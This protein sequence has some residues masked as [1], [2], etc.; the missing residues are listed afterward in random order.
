MVTISFDYSDLDTL[1]CAL[2]SYKSSCKEMLDIDGLS[3]DFYKSQ[4]NEIRR[5][6]SLLVKI[7][8]HE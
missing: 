4:F 3:S 5:I 6:E 2:I 8:N 7:Y 1:V